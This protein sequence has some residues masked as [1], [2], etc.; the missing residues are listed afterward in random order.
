VDVK[1]TIIHGFF[2]SLQVQNRIDSMQAIPINSQKLKVLYV[3]KLIFIDSLSFLDASLD[4][5]TDMLNSSNYTFGRTR[6][7]TGVHH[8]SNP[9]YFVAEKIL[10]WIHEEKIEAMRKENQSG[11]DKVDKDHGRNRPAHRD[12]TGKETYH[13]TREYRLL[14]ARRNNVTREV[15]TRV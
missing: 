6:Q 4:S 2:S 1:V 3:N 14:M 11:K 7:W 12:F 8:L 10:G 13:M 15:S 5:L 9:S